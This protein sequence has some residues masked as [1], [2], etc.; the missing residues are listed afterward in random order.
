[1]SD[2]ILNF[3]AE[4][5]LNAT[6]RQQGVSAERVLSDALGIA[7]QF[8]SCLIIGFLDDGSIYA[9]DTQEHFGDTLLAIERF[10]QA[11][12]LGFEDSLASEPDASA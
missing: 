9:A 3:P 7:D 6:P 4:R 5:E 11:M 12:M 1:M 2:N 8:A 10:K